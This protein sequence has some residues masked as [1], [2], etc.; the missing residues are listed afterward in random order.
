MVAEGVVSRVG[1][2][3]V[4]NDAAYARFLTRRAR[5]VAGYRPPPNRRRTE[6]REGE[7]AS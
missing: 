1:R 4:F 7:A 2:T 5:R 3:L 6:P